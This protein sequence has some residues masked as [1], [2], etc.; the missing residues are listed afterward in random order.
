MRE[1]GA[2]YT[3]AEAKQAHLYFEANGWMWGKNPV[4]DPRAAIERQIQTDRNH[5]TKGYTNGQQ[6][7]KR[8]IPQRK[9]GQF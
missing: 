1:A 8:A 6:Q 9:P 2:D 7:P 4:A 3:D 5:Q